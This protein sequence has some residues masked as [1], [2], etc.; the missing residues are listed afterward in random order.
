LGF[1]TRQGDITGEI[2]LSD[3]NFSQKSLAIRLFLFCPVWNAN[4]A[5]LCTEAAPKAVCFLE[6][7]NMFSGGKTYVE[8]KKEPAFQAAGFGYSAV[9]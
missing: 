8:R 5:A 3:C 6:K 1:Q 9:I 4:R 2:L 7:K